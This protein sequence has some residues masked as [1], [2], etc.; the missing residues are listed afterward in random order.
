MITEISQHAN[1]LSYNWIL[2]NSMSNESRYLIEDWQQF[3]KEDVD[4]DLGEDEMYL[5]H[6]SSVPNIEV[7]D[8]AIA[9]KGP[10]A[11]TRAEYRAW[12]RPRVFF[13]TDWGQ[14]ATTIGR[15]GGGNVYR[16]KLKKDEL[17]PIYE[18][19]LKL[20][21]PDMKEKYVEIAGQYG[22]GM[23]NVFERVATLAQELHGYKGFIYPQNKDKSKIIVA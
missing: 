20:S 5:Y 4:V 21:Y 3:L 17:Y 23:Y 1:A 11:Y 6:V 9:A 12:D 16:V 18:D 22:H 8:P 13:F 15:I 10:R 19:P 14:K 7:L 2:I